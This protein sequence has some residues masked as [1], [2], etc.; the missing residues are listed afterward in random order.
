MGVLRSDA[1]YCEGV[2]AGQALK[3]KT[4]DGLPFA[5]LSDHVFGDVPVVPLVSSD[6]DG[7][8]VDRAGRRSRLVGV[9]NTRLAQFALLPT[10]ARF[11]SSP[12]SLCK[13]PYVR[14]VVWATAQA[15]IVFRWRA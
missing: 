10:I 3:R 1:A 14:S 9:R 13:L 11:S 12:V 8:N 6:V 5:Q 2:A 7:F 15:L 4:A